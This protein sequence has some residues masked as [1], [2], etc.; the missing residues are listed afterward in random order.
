MGCV[1]TRVSTRDG[2][3][4][5]GKWLGSKWNRCLLGSVNRRGDVRD[6]SSYRDVLYLI[7]KTVLK[8]V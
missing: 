3:G 2:G 8:I 7:D 1:D 4:G 5:G 6:V